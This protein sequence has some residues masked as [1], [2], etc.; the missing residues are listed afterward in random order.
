M[1][2]S[3]EVLQAPDVRNARDDEKQAFTDMIDR[4]Q[5]T[6]VDHPRRGLY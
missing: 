3:V 1:Q 5:K 6:M 2:L 4:A